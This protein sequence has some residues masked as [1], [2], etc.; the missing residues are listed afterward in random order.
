MGSVNEGHVFDSNILIYHINGQLDSAA[1]QALSVYFE[2]PAYISTITAME[3]LSW[4]GHSDESV[5]MTTAFLEIFDEIAIDAEIKVGAIRIRRN[6]RLKL[7]DAIIAATAL[8]LVLPLITRNLKD[9]KDIPELRLINPFGESK[10]Y[11]R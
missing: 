7:P 11:N 9:F 8:Y 1:E 2:Q 3:V 6:Y 10:G 4:P 5:E